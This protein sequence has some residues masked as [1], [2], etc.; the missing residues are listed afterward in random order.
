MLSDY[1]PIIVVL[2]LL[3]SFVSIIMFIPMGVDLLYGHKDYQAFLISSSFTGLMSFLTL[4]SQWMKNLKIPLHQGFFLSV[5]SWI[6]IPAFGA[7][8]FVLSSLE[9]SYAAA[10]FEAMSGLTTTGSTVIAD[11]NQASPGI[12][13]WRAILQW[14]GGV[15]ILLMALMVF[16]LLN[17]AGM[18]MFKVEAFENHGKVT[19]RAREF[20][21]QVLL[22]YCFGT[23]MIVLLLLL[24]GLNTFDALV[25]A[26]TT[27]STGGYGAYSS[28]IQHFN[29]LGTE[30]VIMV[31]MVLGSIPFLLFAQMIKN[32]S[33]KPFF[34]DDQV[35]L[36]FTILF[37]VIVLV[38]AWLVLF[39]FYPNFLLALRYGSFQVISLMTGTGFTTMD[40]SLWYGFPGLMLFFLMFVGGCA[41]STACGIKVFRVQ[42]LLQSAKIQILKLFCPHAVFVQTYNRKPLDSGIVEA[43]M[44]YFFLYML[45]VATVALLVSATGLD[46]LTSIGA[47]VT[48]ISNVGPGI[49]H[50]IGPSGSF[51]KLDALAYWV[52]SFG[53][54][55]GRL[56]FVILLAVIFPKVFNR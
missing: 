16:P 31:G 46:I 20:A 47:S 30:I 25:H 10:F 29:N 7:L 39:D 6:F 13:V 1:R 18:Q 15:G 9:L 34:V 53:M 37:V 56:E 5:F 28:S 14:I 41:G 33:L 2:G 52:L 22:L 42:I 36:F 21:T 49:G 26:L 32:K 44:G 35:R 54:L 27:V 38:S 43:V 24:T 3:L 17:I 55:L 23:V 12:I 45:S 50:I 40:Y 51:D 48:A 8:P 19:P 4:L 11:L